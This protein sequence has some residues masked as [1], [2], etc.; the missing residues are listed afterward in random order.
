MQNST[1]ES[2]QHDDNGIFV[3]DQYF[4][5]MRDQFQRWATFLNMGFGFV[6]FSLALACLGTNSPVVNAWFC[7]IVMGY[8]RFKS[9]H[10]FPNEIL[11][12]RKLA[13]KD[14]KARIVLAG[15]EKEFLN[16][17]TL[18][19]GHPI[20]LIGFILLA[21]IATSPFLTPVAP[22]LKTYIVGP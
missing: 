17:K 3:D 18:V 6:S 11:R 20:F 14:P 19:F 21:I 13:K 5:R 16:W 10:L 12:L 9:S 15:L 22:L 2:E 1:T 4:E 7:L 8:I